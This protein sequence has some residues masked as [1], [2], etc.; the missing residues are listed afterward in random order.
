MLHRKTQPAT[1]TD[2]RSRLMIVDDNV[3]TRKMM[4]V[5]LS[6]EGYDVLEVGDA[7]SAI[8]ES[9]KFLPDLVLMDL[10]LP[11]LGGVETIE[12]IRKHAALGDVPVVFVS[13]FALQSDLKKAEEIRY[14]RHLVKPFTLDELYHAVRALSIYWGA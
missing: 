8:R 1:F 6:I 7:D 4:R 3:D 9:T 2:R 10:A 11:R 5:A 12:R 13:G 14:H